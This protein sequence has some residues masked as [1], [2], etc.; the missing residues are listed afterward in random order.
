MV[1]KITGCLFWIKSLNLALSDASSDWI[2]V[3]NF[4]QKI[5][6]KWCYI[7]SLECYQVIHDFEVSLCWLC[8]LFSLACVCVCVCVVFKSQQVH[9]I[10]L[11]NPKTGWASEGPG[12]SRFVFGWPKSSFRFFS[13][14]LYGETQTN[15]WANSI[16]SLPSITNSASLLCLPLGGNSSDG[17]KSRFIE[18]D[19]QKWDT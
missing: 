19:L 16:P 3:V 4:W 5:M 9:E 14:A 10:G 18:M 2:Q 11:S 17:N 15:F 1:F 6:E 7:L 8:S 12:V 13:V